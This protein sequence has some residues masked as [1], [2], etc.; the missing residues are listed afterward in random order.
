M[1]YEVLCQEVWNPEGKILFREALLRELEDSAIDAEDARL[2][3]YN[4]G[5]PLP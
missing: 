5:E 1:T 3:T 2:L 4:L